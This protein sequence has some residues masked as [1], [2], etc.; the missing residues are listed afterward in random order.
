MITHVG[1]YAAHVVYEYRT[2]LWIASI[3]WLVATIL[4]DRSLG[5]DVP[6]ALPWSVM[7]SYAVAIC[8]YLAATA[9]VVGPEI[10]R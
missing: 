8:I 1:H 5:D 10:V 6:H 3:A 9:V 4:W 7:L 2:Q